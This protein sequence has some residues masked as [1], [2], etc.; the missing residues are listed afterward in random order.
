MCVA[1]VH[2][3]K[4]TLAL[5]GQVTQ[6][7]CPADSAA[8]G[9]CKVEVVAGGCSYAAD[10]A[11][12]GGV[13]VLL[14]LN[15]SVYRQPV[16]LAGHLLVFKASPNPQML[17]SVAGK[18]A[19]HAV[20]RRVC[21]SV[22]IANHILFIKDNVCIPFRYVLFLRQYTEYYKNYIVN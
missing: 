12:Q 1:G 20:C 3:Q 18:K 5:A 8:G 11:V 7:N 2:F 19:S 14:K 10:G 16:C 22:V 4:I 21:K 15:G 13:P 6:S 17:S 9:V